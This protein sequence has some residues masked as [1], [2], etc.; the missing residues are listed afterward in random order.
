MEKEVIRVVG[1]TNSWFKVNLTELAK[2][3][4]SSMRENVDLLRSV[5]E[6]CSITDNQSATKIKIYETKQQLK[7]KSKWKFGCKKYIK[8]NRIELILTAT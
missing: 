5:Y 3:W 2:V 4:S 6:P 8:I 7:C 1:M